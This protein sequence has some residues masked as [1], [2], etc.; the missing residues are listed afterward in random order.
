M[1]GAAITPC[2]LIPTRAEPGLGFVTRT[3]IACR[4]RPVVRTGPDGRP[5]RPQR[6][7]GPVPAGMGRG[8]GHFVTKLTKGPEPC[9]SGP[10]LRS[11]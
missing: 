4:A 1:N 9:G 3:S 6:S 8:S 7:G 5:G 2:I 11:G 10:F